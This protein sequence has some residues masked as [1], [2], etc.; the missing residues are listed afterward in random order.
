VLKGL[1][2]LS[3]ALAAGDGEVAAEAMRAHLDKAKQILI[4]KI[5]RS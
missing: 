1:K 2:R 5:R 3:A 4:D